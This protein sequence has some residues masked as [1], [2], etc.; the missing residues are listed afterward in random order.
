M[1]TG[2]GPSRDDRRAIRRWLCARLPRPQRCG[3]LPAGRGGEAR[4]VRIGPACPQDTP[5]RV[6]TARGSE[7]EATRA[8]QAGGLRFPRAH[9]Q[10]PTDTRREVLIGAQPDGEADERAKAQSLGRVM[11][12]WLEHNPAPTSYPP[13]APLFRHYLQKLGLRGCRKKSLNDCF[14]WERLA[15]HCMQFWPRTRIIHA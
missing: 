8:G 15:A 4:W 2:R 14:E 11:N 7:P 3:M 9:Q 10:L 12:G 1:E 5:A 6:W 13:R